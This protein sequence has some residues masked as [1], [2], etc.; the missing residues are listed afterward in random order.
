MSKIDI[1][2]PDAKVLIVDDDRAMRDGLDNLFRSVALQVHTFPSAAEFLA[3]EPSAS[4]A[5]LV[6][7][8]R[9]PELNGIELHQTLRDSMPDMPVIF[10]SAYG[11]TPTAVSALKAGA[12]DFLDKPFQ[13]RDLL[14]AV[15]RGLTLSGERIECSAMLSILRRSFEKLTQREREIMVLLSSGLR[16]KHIGIRLGLSEV[17]I[18][19]HRANVMRKLEIDSLVDLVRI[20]DALGMHT[21]DEIRGATPA[22]MCCRPNEGLRLLAASRRKTA[23]PR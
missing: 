2:P 5:C 20:A 1:Y 6:L 10:I 23:P 14:D 19:M 3:F 8:V 21:V 18:K 12:I 4:P 7:D 17:T 15:W 13:E 16:N 11:D 22:S 9:L